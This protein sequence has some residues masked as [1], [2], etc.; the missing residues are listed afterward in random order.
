MAETIAVYDSRSREYHD[1]FQVFLDHTDQ[2]LKAQKVLSGLIDG[3]PSRRVFIDAGAGNG[4]VT[5]WFTGRFARTVAI[6]PNA[7]LRHDL[8]R[9]CPTAEIVA[10]QIL[11]ARV[12]TSGDLILCSHVFYYI[13]ASEWMPT[14]E[15]LA[16][17]LAPGGLLVILVQ[18]HDTDCMHMLNHFFGKRFLVSSLARQ[19]EE[20]HAR[21]YAVQIDTDAARIE[22]RD[23]RS[24]YGIGEF[25]LN[26]LPISQPPERRALEGY[27]Q[28]HF[29][30]PDGSFRFS[31]DQDFIQIRKRD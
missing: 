3:L 19:F 14:L 29:E 22:T 9:S 7:S 16:S 10:D 23:F 15:R 30:R 4:M 17:W 31:C 13:D 24:A 21:S 28:S 1:A 5:S 25:M 12:A 2:K 8:A 18:N 26:L 6:E 27:V 20:A 11:N